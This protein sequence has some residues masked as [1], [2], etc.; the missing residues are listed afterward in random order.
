M[1]LV[2][3]LFFSTVYLFKRLYELI[4][5]LIYPPYCAQ[6]KK[7]LEN[8]SVFCKECALQIQSVATIPLKVT[9]KWSI[10][11]LALS[12]YKKPIQQLILAKGR[13]NRTASYQLAKLIWDRT[14]IRNLSVDYFIP[15]PLHWRRYAKRGYNQAEVI[16][17]YLAEKKGADVYNGLQRVKHTKF[18]SSCS[19]QGRADNVKDAF[20]LCVT[21]NNQF[22][23]K[24]LVIVDDLMTTGSTLQAAVRELCKVRPASITAIVACRVTSK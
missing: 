6:C 9:K 15:I 20:S 18:Q 11:V 2:K 5:Y 1:K 12:A 21:D 13:S 17:K 4:T 14:P 10:P 19:G 8:R 23:G 16:A 22:K 7:F 3:R 24:H